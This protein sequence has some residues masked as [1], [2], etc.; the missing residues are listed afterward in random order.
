M[1][2]FCYQILTPLAPFFF[3]TPS[4]NSQTPQC[5]LKCIVS[6]CPTSDD[7]A[8][9]NR[10]K[11]FP[12]SLWVCMGCTINSTGQLRYIRRKLMNTL[13]KYLKCCACTISSTDSLWLL[14]HCLLFVVSAF[15]ELQLETMHWCCKNCP[16][17]NSWSEKFTNVLFHYVLL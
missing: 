1:F 11:V 8:L 14:L 7:G 10:A 5:P 4:F 17:F 13:N 15:R 6:H 12:A 2:F 3:L 9:H 16:V